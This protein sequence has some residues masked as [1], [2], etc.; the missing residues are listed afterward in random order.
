MT[1][2]TARHL[3]V[4]TPERAAPLVDDVSFEIGAER[5]AIVGASGSGKSLTSRA[6]MGLLKPP[7]RLQADELR[8]EGEDLRAFGARDW[9]GIRGSRL[10]LVLQDPRFSLNPT[11]T[12][13]RQIEEMLVLHETAP[14][15]ERR[16]R[17]E[18][19]LRDVG[20]DETILDRHPHQLSGGMGQR[21]VLAM[22]L[23]N[24][25][26][27]LIADEPTSA[28][29]AATRTQALELIRDAVD[30]RGMGLLLISHDLREVARFCHR[31]LVMWRGRIVDECQAAD[32]PTARHPYTRTLWACAPSGRTHG[33]R[34]PTLESLDEDRF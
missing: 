15:A 26:R 30:R 25:P 16:R 13:Q 12:V 28:L 8:F 6:L 3:T 18:A 34:L 23:M 21:V 32:L 22:M 33:T 11:L 5:V 31:V 24:R 17:V 1:I 27:L 20:L 4:R 7:L 9:R 14:R 10:S 19:A 2:L 29:D